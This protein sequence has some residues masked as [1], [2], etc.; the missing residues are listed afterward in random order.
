MK[1]INYLREL[2]QVAKRRYYFAYHARFGWEYKF[3]PIGSEMPDYFM[4]HSKENLKQ[5]CSAWGVPS[6]YFEMGDWEVDSGPSDAIEIMEVEE[7]EG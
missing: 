5:I 2:Y 7:V 1:L 4:E 3:T 6:R